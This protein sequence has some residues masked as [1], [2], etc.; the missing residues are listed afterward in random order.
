MVE[1]I[2]EIVDNR[3]AAHG[4]AIETSAVGESDTNA[5]VE[6]AIQD[7]EGQVRTLRV[8]LE[9]RLKE[10]V[11]IRDPVVPW[12]VRH[13]GCLIIMCRVRPNGKTALEMIKG[14]KA[15]MKITEFGDNESEES[16]GT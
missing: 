16:I 15:N 3:K 4:T 1:V 12:L 7:V 2:R 8:G 9:A 6:R 11:H 13:A 10:K 5:T 14:R